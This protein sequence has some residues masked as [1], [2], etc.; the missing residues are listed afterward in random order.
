M[1]KKTAEPKTLPDDVPVE[2]P[3]LPK[4]LVV[5][6][7]QQLKAAGDPLRTRIL[8]IIQH[9][10]A[11]AK[12]IADRL[13]AS[14]G[15]IGHHLK[16]LEDAGLAQVVARRVTRGII[17]KYYTRTARIFHFAAPVEAGDRPAATVDILGDAYAEWKEAQQEDQSYYGDDQYVGFP[18][19]RLSAKKAKAYA[20]RAQKLV[21]DLLNEAPDPNGAVYGLGVAFFVSPAYMQ[22]ET[23]SRAK[24]ARAKSE[25]ATKG[26]KKSKS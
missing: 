4:S 8:F 24:P 25:G 7:P 2:M 16:V 23:E 21:D 3:E 14:P 13:G 6:T 22:V 15:A 17:A 19:A 11:T 20:L 18:H 5:N 10:P 9:Q 12:Q 26:A 1:K